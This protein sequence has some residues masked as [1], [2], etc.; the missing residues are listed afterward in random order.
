MHAQVLRIHWH[1]KQP[2]FSVAFDPNDERR[3]ATAGGDNSVRIWRLTRHRSDKPER[4]A[5]DVE[6]GPDGAAS[7]DGGGGDTLY[8]EYC[9]TLSRHIRPVNCVAFSPD[10][11]YLGSAGDGGS[12]ILWSRS[13]QPARRV[14]RIFGEDLSQS[15]DDDDCDMRD[16]PHDGASSSASRPSISGGDGGGPLVKAFKEHWSVVA[17]FR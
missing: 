10:G 7:A 5:G 9:A 11:L 8:P 4:S 15:S 13:E 6:R 14:V 16:G 2:V 12:L 1:D 17:V 3:I